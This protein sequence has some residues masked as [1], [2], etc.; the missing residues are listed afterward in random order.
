MIDGKYLGPRNFAAPHVTRS[1]SLLKPPEPK[2]GKFPRIP[3]PEV[4]KCH[5]NASVAIDNTVFVSRTSQWSGCCRT[6]HFSISLHRHYSSQPY[7]GS[8]EALQNVKMKVHM[9]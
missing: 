8:Q 3:P 5:T 2:L 9:F 7:T 4:F 1:S 6:K